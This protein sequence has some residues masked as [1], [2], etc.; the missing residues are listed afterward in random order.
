MFEYI[1]KILAQGQNKLRIVIYLKSI[2]YK[3]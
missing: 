2:S 1:N 3:K